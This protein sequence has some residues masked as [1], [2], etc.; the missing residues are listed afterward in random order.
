MWNNN[1]Y[2]IRIEDNSIFEYERI[3]LSSG[4]CDFLFPMV[5]MGENGRETAYYSCSGFTPL[6]SYNIEKMD[7]ALF[8]L[9]KTLLIVSHVA[10]YLI[11]PSKVMLSTDTVFYNSESGEIKIAYVP[12][13]SETVNLRHNIMTFI[14][15]LKAEVSCADKS[16]LDKIA[17][18]IHYG[19]YQMKDVINYIGKLKRELYSRTR[20]S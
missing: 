20:T 11:S 8:I 5:F 16:Y 1:E 15:Q 17:R 10:E 19:N 4:E 2:K 14:A 13:R 7:D 6:S 9:E 18:M 3:V 12:V